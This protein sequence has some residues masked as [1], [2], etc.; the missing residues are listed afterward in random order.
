MDPCEQLNAVN[1]RT[2][3]SV[4]DFVLHNLACLW[5][6]VPEVVLDFVPIIL[7]DRVKKR[8][9]HILFCQIL[10]DVDIGSLATISMQFS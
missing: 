5:C 3:A 1:G 8:I 9:H 6:S 7:T 2:P 4:S 10:I